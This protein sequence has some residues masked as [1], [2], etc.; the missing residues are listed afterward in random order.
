VENFLCRTKTLSFFFIIQISKTLIHQMLFREATTADIQQI[1]S[2]RNSVKEN[3]L[4]DPAL[5]SDEDCEM[6]LTQ[7]GKGW[8][9]EMDSRIVGFAIADLK[10]HNIWALFI[11]PDFEKQGIGKTLHDMMLDWYFQ[12]TQQLVWL[13]TAPGTRAEA[14]YKK[15]GWSLNGMH[16]KELKF[17]MERADWTKGR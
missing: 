16:G 6:F 8:V 7:R 4:S 14:F 12:Q 3:T 2:V 5:V 13:G 10:E 1:Q 15:A 11:H 9:C 17:E